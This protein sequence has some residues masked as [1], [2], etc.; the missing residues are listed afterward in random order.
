[1]ILA[2]PFNQISKRRAVIAT[3]WFLIGL[4]ACNICLIVYYISFTYHVDF[5]SDSAVKNLLAQEI[6]ETCQ[7]F[8]VDWNYVNN[9]LFVLFGHNYVLFLL[10][11]FKNSF[12]L[13]AVSGLLSAALILLGTWCVASI[14]STAILTRLVSVL[15][16]SSGFSALTA[17][18]MYG[19]VSYGSI[20]YIICFAIFFSWRYLNTESKNAVRLWGTAFIILIVLAS[21]G[22][23]SRGLIYCGLPLFTAALV[24]VAVELRESHGLL[25][26]SSFRG[27][28]LLGLI[29][30][31]STIG[32]ILHKASIANVH[33]VMEATKAQWLSPEGMLK[34]IAFTLQGL[35][36]IFG[37]FPSQSELVVSASGV[38]ES[39]RFFSAIVLIVLMPYGLLLAFR[40]KNRGKVFIAVFS[41][42]LAGLSLFFQITT[43]IPNM[44]DPIQSARYLL[45]ASLLLALLLADL[46]SDGSANAASRIVTTG[47]IFVLATSSFFNLLIP[48][49]TS[50]FV[51]QQPQSNRSLLVK[52]LQANGLHYG[53]ATYW[54]A[55]VLSVLSE[56]DVRVRQIRLDRGL[57][58]PMKHLSSDRWYRPSAWGGET[59]L[60]LTNEEAKTVDLDLLA[61]YNS[62]LERRLQ[63]LDW[64]IFV[65]QKNIA[66]SL[67]NWGTSAGEAMVDGLPVSGF[68]VRL[69]PKVKE[70]S[71]SPGKRSYLPIVVTNIGDSRWSSTSKDGGWG[72]NTVALSYHVRAL[73]GKL[74]EF[75]GLR[76]L[77]P[78]NIMPGQQ[79]QL[80]GDFIAPIKPGKYLLEFDM[81]Q[82]GVSWFSA[83]GGA[84]AT[85]S[86][87]AE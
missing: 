2:D 61:N 58:I 57:P 68:K 67:P 42:V 74:L 87:I 69:E 73:D 55:G 35:I 78:G 41:V 66:G 79:V 5:H 56:Q 26:R 52:F 30:I 3:K 51:W 15:I 81:V 40:S 85:I 82:E 34:N 77:I 37:R 13:H 24:S 33:N 50:Q 54:N 19:Q 27:L 48:A 22:N 28:S 20:Y 11:F 62:K 10:P 25:Q 31:G 16:I 23:P 80:S 29:L 18:N 12:A 14:I 84:T 60:L 32:F 64:Q 83:K 4:L 1:M 65:F 53:Y 70:I 36:S 43:T 45:P 63:F 86:L 44:S 76:T 9:D 47:A 46:I 7:Y 71:A 21:W 49:S 59:F 38:Y 72:L 75:E 8:P 17:E 39:A 6:Y